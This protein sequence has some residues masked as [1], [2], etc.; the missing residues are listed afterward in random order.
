MA[1][2]TAT[3]QF[4]NQ[5]SELIGDGTIDLDNDSFECIL[6]TNGHTV[7]LDDVSN[8]DLD[9]EVSGNGYSRQALASVTWNRSGDTTTFD[10]G[11]PVFNASGGS[12]TARR[13]VIR[14]VTADRL[15]CVGLLDNGDADVVT[16][17]G[18]SLT[19]QINASGLF[20]S[21]PA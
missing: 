1:T 4:Y 14:D 21:A 9:N 20:T 16:T 8:S 6:L 7:N 15:V 2:T 10:F 13:Y 11:D 5:V 12:I 17:D 18:N 19:L 3:I